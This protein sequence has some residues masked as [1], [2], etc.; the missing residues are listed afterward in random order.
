MTS[1]VQAPAPPSGL[2]QAAP[3]GRTRNHGEL[4]G[5]PRGSRGCCAALP[6]SPGLSGW[7]GTRANRAEHGPDCL[8]TVLQAALWAVLLQS[9][10]PRAR[11]CRPRPEAGWARACLGRGEEAPSGSHVL[12]AHGTPAEPADH[13][14]AEGTL[15]AGA[16]RPVFPGMEM[17]Q[18]APQDSVRGEESPQATSP[19]HQK[20][21]VQAWRMVCGVWRVGAARSQA[22]VGI[23]WSSTREEFRTPCSSQLEFVTLWGSLHFQQTGRHPNMS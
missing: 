19:G 8:G 1:R 21:R 13:L 7:E 3:S 18:H 6:G 2:G 23:H 4:D 15:V 11:P 14:H 5:W 9:P 10:G 20:P 17:C 22:P 12:G 16:H